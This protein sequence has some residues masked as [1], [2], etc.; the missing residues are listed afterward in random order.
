[1]HEAIPIVFSPP[2]FNCFNLKDSPFCLP[3]GGPI[4]FKLYIYPWRIV[5][6]CFYETIV[7]CSWANHPSRSTIEKF[8]IPRLLYY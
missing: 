7:L 3:V 6:F 1:M 4:K 2:Q 8:E 5:L